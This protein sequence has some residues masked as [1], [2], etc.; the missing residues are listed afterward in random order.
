[1]SHPGN[2]SPEGQGVEQIGGTQGVEAGHFNFQNKYWS[3]VGG[4]PDA[5]APYDPGDLIE[6][7][8]AIRHLPMVVAH[9][10][11]KAQE[12]IAM[13]EDPENFEVVLQNRSDTERPRAYIAPANSDGIGAELEDA[14]L[15]KAAINMQGR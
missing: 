8:K 7:G 12:C 11:D 15:L 10:V 4:E 2:W 3:T 9:C 14:V 6:L 13:I 1:M 5:H